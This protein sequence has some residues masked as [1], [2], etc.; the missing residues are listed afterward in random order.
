MPTS[1]KTGIRRSKKRRATV[2]LGG[3][4]QSAFAGYAPSSGQPKQ[5]TP[6]V[7]PADKKSEEDS[8]P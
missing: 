6:E 4:S 5:P 7:E 1:K 2:S 8:A 3:V